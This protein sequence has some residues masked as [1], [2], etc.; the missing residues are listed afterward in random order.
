MTDKPKS[1]TPERIYLQAGDDRDTFDD[2]DGVT[3]CKDQINDSDIEY[4]RAD[5]HD[6][7]NAEITRLQ[8]AN[9]NLIGLLREVMA[10]RPQESI[11]Y[12][13]LQIK[14]VNG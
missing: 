12:V 4:V 1:D 13:E 2:M 9:D 5:V 11:E 6:I 3:W 8:I 10:G 14:K 7:A